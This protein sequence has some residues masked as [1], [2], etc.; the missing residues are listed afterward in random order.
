MESHDD[1][2][3]LGVETLSPSRAQQYVCQAASRIE[4]IEPSSGLDQYDRKECGQR[5]QEY[6]MS[7]AFFGLIT[8]SRKTALF[9]PIP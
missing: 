6:R 9:P 3:N 7:L 4:S 1:E 5:Q 2:N 8:L